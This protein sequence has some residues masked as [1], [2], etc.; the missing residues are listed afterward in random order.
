MRSDQFSAKIVT[1]RAGDG[2]VQVPVA[3][4]IDAGTAGGRVHRPSAAAA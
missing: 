3:G 2:P 4:D 1:A